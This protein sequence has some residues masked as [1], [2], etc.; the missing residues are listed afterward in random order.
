MNSNTRCFI[1]APDGYEEIRYAELVERRLQDPAY[2]HRRFIP[3]H[4]MLMEVGEAEYRRFYRDRRRQKYIAEEAAKNGEVSYHAFGNGE[5]SGESIIADMSLSV[6]DAVSHK[7]ML[8]DMIRCFRQ[9]DDTDRKLL[10]ALYSDGRS[11][12]G[13]AKELGITHQA[14]NKR[15]QKAL[16]KLR[17]LMGL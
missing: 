4:G 1:L 8:E 14:I 10:T 13:L 12:R 2:T 6:D 17:C 3:L 15:Q 5:L 9:L 16:A 7:L 11:E